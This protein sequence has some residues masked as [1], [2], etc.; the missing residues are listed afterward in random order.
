MYGLDARL[1][2]GQGLRREASKAAGFRGYDGLFRFARNDEAV[3]E[4]LY[5]LH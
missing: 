2:S 4:C 5:S 3:T 1:P